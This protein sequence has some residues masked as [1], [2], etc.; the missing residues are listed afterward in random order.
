[1]SSASCQLI[2]FMQEKTNL[3]APQSS[4]SSKNQGR[5]CFSEMK[6]K[7][8]Q[9][10]PACCNPMGCNLSMGF[11]RKEHWSGLPFPSQGIFPIQDQTWVSYIVGRFFTIWATRKAQ[12]M[13]SKFQIT[14][15]IWLKRPE[16]VWCVY[17]PESSLFIKGNAFLI[18]NSIHKHIILNFPTT[19]WILHLFSVA[20]S[21][22]LIV[23]FKKDPI[24]NY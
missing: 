22:N 21:L 18:Y 5:L 2:M 17:S 4:Q 23:I 12:Q 14:N 3:E 24:E 1:M 11:S 15:S 19:E 9:S 8:A 10:C 16:T 13:Q 6:V 7:V 20:I